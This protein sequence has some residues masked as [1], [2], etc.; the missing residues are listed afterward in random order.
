MERQQT[1]ESVQGG[2]RWSA[3]K[4]EN[5]YRMVLDGAPADGRIIIGWCSMER[6]QTG[7]SVQGGAR[8]SA[9]DMKLP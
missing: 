4:R 3:S 5:Q 8:R 7:E 1:G 2:A 6:Q 9:D